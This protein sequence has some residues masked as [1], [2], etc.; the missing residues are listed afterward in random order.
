MNWLRPLLIEL[1]LAYL[2]WALREIDPMHPDLPGIVAEIRQ[3]EAE[4]SAPGFA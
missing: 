2:R 1:R 3:L 4:R